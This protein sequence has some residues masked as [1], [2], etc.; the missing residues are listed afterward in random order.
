MPVGNKEVVIDRYPFEFSGVFWDKK[1]RGL[2]FGWRA[3]TTVRNITIIKML[4]IG[5]SWFPIRFLTSSLDNEK[6]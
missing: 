6:D 5:L 3:D 1:A 2:V 4:V